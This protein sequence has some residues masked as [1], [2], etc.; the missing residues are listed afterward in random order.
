[1]GGERRRGEGQKG[2]EEGLKEKQR[3]SYR[4]W[5]RQ[6]IRTE[7]SREKNLKKDGESAHLISYCSF[8]NLQ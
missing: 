3:D 7:D 8:S 1:M 4:K 6:K 5:V 2:R